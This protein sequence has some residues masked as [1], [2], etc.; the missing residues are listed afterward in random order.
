MQEWNLNHEAVKAFFSFLGSLLT[1]VV[2]LIAGWSF[3]NR[4]TYFWNERQKRREFQLSALQQFYAAYG[5]FFAVWKLWNPLVDASQ[6]STDKGWKLHERAAAAEAIIE[7]TLVKLACEMDLD[8]STIE[9]LGRF[10][11][12][13][14]R[15]RESIRYGK[16]LPW[17]SSENPEYKTF[18]R[19]SIQ[20]SS[21]I[22]G[23]WKR[24]S[25]LQ[26]AEVQLSR[27]TSNSF[28]RNWVDP[29]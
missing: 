19:L 22:A 16:K 9:E 14:Q 5:E 29:G 6:G 25:S 21:L 10:R 4:V 28:E 12:G 7:G 2:A 1:L 24:P 20:V 26:N 3:G 8:D 23:E 13:F 18:K 15:L 27:I 11:Q 17:D